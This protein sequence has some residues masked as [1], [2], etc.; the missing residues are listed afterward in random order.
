M[1]Q[2]AHCYQIRSAFNAIMHSLC[3]HQLMCLLQFAT[4]NHLLPTTFDS[5]V[6][7]RNNQ[8]GKVNPSAS[9][10][11]L[12]AANSE[13]DG[14][15]YAS[16]SVPY[17]LSATPRDSDA[18]TTHRDE[19]DLDVLAIDIRITFTIKVFFDLVRQYGG[20]LLTD[21]W[22]SVMKVLLWLFHL[23]L[24]PHSIFEMEDFTD[25]TGIPLPSLSDPIKDDEAQ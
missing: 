2:I 13:L 5:S 25:A 4:Q 9:L 14:V 1:G 15:N 21:G 3:N 23:D 19:Q 18:T 10:Q 16:I 12:H 20:L 24:I 17:F 22:S 11:S 8:S 6:I 7:T